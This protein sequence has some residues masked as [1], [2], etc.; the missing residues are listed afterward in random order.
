MLCY[1]ADRADC[2]AHEALPE[3]ASLNALCGALATL[4]HAARRPLPAGALLGAALGFAALS[5][6]WI[7][8]ASLLVA[9][10]A[11]HIA[12]PGWRTRNAW[13][14][15]G[16]SLLVGFLIAANWPLALYWRA[17]EAFAL[18]RTVAWQPLGDPLANLRFFL[19]TGSWFAWP[20]WPLALWAAW[21]LRRRW[22]E[23][24]IFV[25]AL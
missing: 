5:A 18:W 4:P 7:A 15:L 9:V 13:V 25:T 10:V 23:P 12:C 11:A 8:P 22:N 16:V 24:Q 17:P 1:S 19:V 20:A 2:A 14:F 21:S 6:L 3:L